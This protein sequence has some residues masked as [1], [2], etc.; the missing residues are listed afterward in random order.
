MIHNLKRKLIRFF[1][2]T[3][4]YF[5]ARK[6]QIVFESFLG[7]QYGCNPKAIY[8]YMKIHH[9]DYSMYWSVDKNFA[10]NFQE[11]DIK[12]IF[13]YSIRWIFVMAFS[14]FWIS[15][16]RLPSYLIKPKHTKYIQTW[17]GTPLKKLVLDMDEVHMPETTTTEYKNNFLNESSKWDSL[18]SPNRYS[19]N[20]FKRAFAFE[21]DIIEIGYPRND[22]LTNDNN[23]VKITALKKKF[24]LPQDKKI[25][26]YAPT[27]RDNQ[28]YNKGLYKFEL[29][30]DLALLK[31][32]YQEDCVIILRMHYL[33]A[34]NIDTKK[35][36]NFVYD[37]SSGFDIN[38]LYLI[39]DLLVTDYSSVFF[40]Y[41]NLKRP[42]LFYMYDLDEYRD[43]LRGFYFDITQKSPGPIVTTTHEL[44][45]ELDYFIETGEILFNDEFYDKFYNKFC[46]LED[47]N[48]TKRFVENYIV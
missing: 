26:L 46:Y 18:V 3:V 32:K 23:P 11:D 28:F 24:D 22:V 48:V 33:V 41:A 17:H 7:K 45:K 10:S 15:N 35:Y 8:V 43:T 9:P 42:I 30:L 36:E 34:E 31:E 1:L 37:F 21:K 47:G 40:D 12:I 38:D 29:E 4:G 14:R 39:S 25:I 2:F 16:S 44:T 19:T 5:P 13:R 27:W 6:N 20:I